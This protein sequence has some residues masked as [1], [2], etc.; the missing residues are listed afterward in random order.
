M[1]MFRKKRIFSQGF[2]LI[3]LLVVIAIIGLLAAIVLVSFN[4]TRAKSRDAQRVAEIKNL[5]MALALY[6]DDN[7]QF[8]VTGDCSTNSWIVLDGAT[9][10]VSQALIALGFFPAGGAPYDPRSPGQEYEYK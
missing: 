8:V 5:K 9:D 6:H 10:A 4:L 1:F 3:E 7:D 2:T